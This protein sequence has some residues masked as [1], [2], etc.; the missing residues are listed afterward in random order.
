MAIRPGPQPEEH[1]RAAN[2][3]GPELE[4]YSPRA[5]ASRAGSGA[6]HDDNGTPVAGGSGYANDVVAASCTAGKANGHMTSHRQPAQVRGTRAVDRGGLP[7]LDSCFWSL[8]A[9]ARAETGRIWRALRGRRG[10]KPQGKTGPF[11]SDRETRLPVP[12]M[13]SPSPFRRSGGTESVRCPALRRRPR[14]PGWRARRCPTTSCAWARGPD[15]HAAHNR[16]DTPGLQCRAAG[17]AAGMGV[18]S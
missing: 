1:T 13:W 11:E 9:R 2:R 6:D 3:G 4:T 14:L 16:G 8:A 18:V 17:R 10:V 15:R 5:R 12:A 7:P